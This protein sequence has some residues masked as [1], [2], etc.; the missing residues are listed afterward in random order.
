[1]S[2]DIQTT[3]SYTYV[4]ADSTRLLKDICSKLR[5]DEDIPAIFSG[6]PYFA[7]GTGI[8]LTVAQT[9]HLVR[10]VESVRLLLTELQRA[11]A[12]GEYYLRSRLSALQ[13]QEGFAKLPDDVVSHI[14][15]LACG[16][17]DVKTPVLISSVS[18]R[19][20]QLALRL[21]NLWT[22]ISAH[23]QNHLQAQ[24]F[25]TRS[26]T[27]KLTVRA[28]G[29]RS[30]FGSNYDLKRTLDMF[31]V[32]VAS[33]SSR[34]VSL[35]IDVEIDNDSSVEFLTTISKSHSSLV[36]PQLE[37]L[38]IFFHD[39]AE[40][41][42][43]IHFCRNWAMPSL[44]SF[45]AGNFIPQFD[46]DVPERLLSFTIELGSDFDEL[47]DEVWEYAAVV[48]LLRRMAR[49][50][51]LSL[52]IRH[53]YFDPQLEVRSKALLPDLRDLQL[54]LGKPGPTSVAN[55]FRYFNCE[56]VTSLRLDAMLKVDMR[57]PEAIVG[58][59]SEC[60]NTP[61]VTDLGITLRY[62]TYPDPQTQTARDQL[63]NLSHSAFLQNVCNL[64]ID[65]PLEEF[66][67]DCILDF[68]GKTREIRV[69][70]CTGQAGAI[71]SRLTTRVNHG[72][73][74]GEAQSGST[75][76]IADPAAW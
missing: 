48:R 60:R 54:D 36:L 67:Y 2:S 6:F 69:E 46:T 65:F 40:N 19:F 13:I 51:S 59:V 16:W 11:A 7:Y 52:S 32:S 18:R 28:T 56:G 35:S 12:S 10:V 1:M 20:R 3:Q 30:Y 71:L 31:S 34:L 68:A 25:V 4:N 17:M 33:V 55:F 57:P 26:A 63:E 47:Q 42:P 64:H 38:R 21:P 50:N 49:L 74:G 41:T 29:V 45:D 5:R 76:V 14:F 39:F 62:C 72:F 58:L 44:H 73:K 75:M 70:N 24:D 22:F 37:Y 43:G 9:L 8:Q 15:E 23:F 53:Q 61:N 66:G 27:Q